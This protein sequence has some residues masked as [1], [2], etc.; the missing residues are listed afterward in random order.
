GADP[1]NKWVLRNVVKY[2]NSLPFIKYLVD[3]GADLKTK[4]LLTNAISSN[5]LPIVQYLVK[6]GADPN[7]GLKKAIRLGYF[8]II[9]Y[10]IE[11]GADPLKLSEKYQRRA[12][13]IQQYEG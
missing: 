4:G 10:L 12:L 1:K 6:N 11:M 2:K 5:D 7:L 9:Q 3:N 13:R 8:H